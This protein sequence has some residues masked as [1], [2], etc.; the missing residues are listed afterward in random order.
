M[1]WVSNFC[2][3]DLI[4]WMYGM[5]EGDCLCLKK[6]SIRFQM[7]ERECVCVCV[8]VRERERENEMKGERDCG[9]VR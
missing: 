6:I 5:P 3:F 1:K 8:C 2:L 9:N 7:R 4:V